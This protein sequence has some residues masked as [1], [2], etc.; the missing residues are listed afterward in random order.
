MAPHEW[1]WTGPDGRIYQVF[2]FPFTDTDGSFLILEMGI[3]ITERKQA[4]KS[5]KVASLYTR[6]LIEASLDPLVT[7]SADGKVMDVNEATELV[8]GVSR[9][10][11][12]GSD[13]SSY[14]TD[15]QK[16][17]KGYKEVFSKGFVRD[18]PL[19]IR[20]TSGRVTEVLYN[21]TV[22]RDD[23]GEVQGV[24]AAAR[25]ITERKRA[26][27]ALQESENQLRQL[28]S[29]LMAAQENERKR[30]ARELHDGLGQILTAIK[31]RVEGFL[32]E[33]GNSRMK[34]K[35]KSLEAII[36]MVQES[37]REIRRIQ[38]DLRPSILDDLGILSTI[39]WFCREFQTTYSHI[40][41]E[42]E[43]DVQEENVPDSLKMII[44]RIMQ[45]A[46]NNISKH[47]QADLIHLA[48]R[49]TTGGLKLS[50]QDN[51]RGFNLQEVL[52]AEGSRQG[53]GLSSM[54][55]RAEHSGGSLSM[56]SAK[57][58]GTLIRV[59]WPT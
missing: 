13:F 35:G 6:S 55:E 10:H 57:G 31:F 42:K 53:L 45:E 3:D 48:F 27:E 29:Q 12:I 1:E 47:S 36:P 7:I 46:L 22:Y 16:A 9:E 17:Q 39:T 19:A 56:E 30:V 40:R 44:Y 20:H 24:F 25:D 51:G 26:E 4:E 41:I 18:Y 37:V 11:L 50:I 21:A 15:P 43:I 8:T 23:A 34:M 28:S 5:L 2:D 14:F 38:T 33:I 32:Q 54:R 49:K 58:K 59:E 52:S